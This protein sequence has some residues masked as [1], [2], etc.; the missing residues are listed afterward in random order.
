ML[1]KLRK[2]REERAEGATGADSGF[3]LIELLVV[4]VI[5]GILIAIAIPLYLNYQKGAKDKSAQS[6]LRGAVATMQQC[7]TDNNNAYPAASDTYAAGDAKMTFTCNGTTE[8]ANLSSG[9]V[10]KYTPTPSGC[11]TACTGFT[12][13]AANSG[14]NKNDTAFATVG[15]YYSYDSTVGGA[16]N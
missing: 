14:G 15:K 3:T 12:M 11:T 6:D 2:I 10:F 1:N 8:T 5:I 13:F 16:V 4:V 7:Y 9:T